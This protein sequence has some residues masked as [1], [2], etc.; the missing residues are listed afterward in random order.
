[1]PATE[2]KLQK[3][4]LIS[5]RVQGVSYRFY[6]RE[7]AQT[8]GLTGWCRNLEDGR[9]E[10]VVSGTPDQ[11]EAILTWCQHGPPAAT[12]TD[13]LVSDVPRE[14]QTTLQRFEIL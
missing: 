13:V 11:L 8:L 1:M 2:K 4:F 10:A 7:K 14:R 12:V 5:G 3:H 9:V 6:M